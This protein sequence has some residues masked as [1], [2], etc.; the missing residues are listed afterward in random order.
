MDPYMAGYL[1]G[2]STLPLKVAPD[3]PFMDGS[4]A[5]LSY[6]RGWLRG[7]HEVIAAR[8]GAVMVGGEIGFP[9]T[10]RLDWPESRRV[11]VQEWLASCSDNALFAH[12]EATRRALEEL[13]KD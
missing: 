6:W 11:V 12:R 1:A 5:A 9:V 3:C 7:E 2:L 13:E 10:F 4:E 8:P